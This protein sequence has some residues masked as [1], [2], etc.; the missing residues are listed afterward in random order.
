[1]FHVSAILVSFFSF[2]FFFYW[3]E[4]KSRIELKILPLTYKCLNNQTSQSHQSTLLFEY[5][6]TFGSLAFEKQNVRHTLQSLGSFPTETSFLGSTVRLPLYFFKISLII[7]MFQL[8]GD[9]FSIPPPLFTPH[10]PLCHYC[11]S[12]TF[13]FFRPQFVFCAHHTVS[14]YSLLFLPLV[15]QSVATNAFFSLNLG[16]P[17]ISSCFERGLPPHHLQVLGLTGSTDC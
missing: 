9:P 4:V 2:F 6:F 1:M 12:L 14:L 15:L 13:V 3:L 16:L 8:L 11:T 17:L 7:L 5:R 10:V